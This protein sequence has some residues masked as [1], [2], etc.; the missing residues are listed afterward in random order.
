[1]APSA[2]PS[3][4]EI[5]VPL[6]APIRLVVPDQSVDAA[7]EEYTNQQVAAEG[8]WVNPLHRDVVAWWSGGGTPGIPADNTVYLYGHVS[9]KPAVFNWLADA[10]IGDT[11]DLTTSA[12]T[13]SYLVTEVLPPVLKSE[14]PNVPEVAAAVPGR[15]VLIGCHRDEDQGTKPTTKNTVV[16]A[17][18]IVGV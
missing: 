10:A 5:N 7:V 6:A 18:Q 12:G 16:I 2:S 14:L 13:I 11:I 1:M 17:Q 8:G 9:S 15:L 4:A 3:A